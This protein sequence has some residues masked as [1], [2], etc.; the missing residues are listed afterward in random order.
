LRRKGAAGSI[1]E[2]GNGLWRDRKNAEFLS[3]H[4]EAFN[5]NDIRKNQAG[6]AHIDLVGT[7]TG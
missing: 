3:D 4:V 7:N 5:S 6:P 1:N 2:L